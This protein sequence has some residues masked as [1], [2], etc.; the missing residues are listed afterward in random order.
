MGTSRL[1]DLIRLVLGAVELILS[2]DNDIKSSSSS[3]VKLPSLVAVC[4]AGLPGADLDEAWDELTDSAGEDAT[5]GWRVR[6]GVVGMDSVGTELALLFDRLECSW[7]PKSTVG[8]A[9]MSPRTKL[10]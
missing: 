8:L 5:F 2:F 4:G 1:A 7:S 10:L 3:K 9:V 6:T